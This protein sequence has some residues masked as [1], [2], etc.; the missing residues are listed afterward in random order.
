MV[1]LAGDPYPET[2]VLAATRLILEN[3]QGYFFNAQRAYPV[4][5]KHFKQTAFT[6][7]LTSLYHLAI[8][9]FY[10]FPYIYTSLSTLINLQA[11]Q[12][13]KFFNLIV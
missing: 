8:C 6:F 4:V 5:G 13:F 7:P 2:L 9:K 10:L 1:L 12:F 11:F 3:I